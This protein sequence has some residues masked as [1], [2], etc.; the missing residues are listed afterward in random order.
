LLGELYER[1]GKRTDAAEVYRQAAENRKLS[2]QERAQF[3]QRAQ[4]L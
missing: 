3:A 4:A 2:E 1:Q